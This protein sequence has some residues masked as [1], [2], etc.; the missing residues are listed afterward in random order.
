[1]RVKAGEHDGLITKQPGAP[2]EWARVTALGFEVGFGARHKEAA[3]LV[4]AM[5]PLELDVA[6]IHHVERARLGQQQIQDIDIGGNGRNLC[7]V[8][9]AW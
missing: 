3:R 8:R 7:R 4:Q 9:P 2:I 1:M 6:S 5:Q